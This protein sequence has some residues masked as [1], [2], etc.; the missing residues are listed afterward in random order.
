ME[1]G[2]IEF[3]ITSLEPGRYSGQCSNCFLHKLKLRN[4][5]D[6]LKKK[7]SRSPKEK[8]RIEFSIF[9]PSLEPG[10][11]EVLNQMAM[12]KYFSR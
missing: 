8:G 1:K 4:F 2:R 5:Q 11:G 12:S 7:K 10:G 9:K 3:F 6:H